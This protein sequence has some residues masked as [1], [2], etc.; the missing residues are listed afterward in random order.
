MIVKMQQND[1]YVNFF[2]SSKFSKYFFN[3]KNKVITKFDIQKT[4]WIW[5]GFF[6]HNQWN[7]FRKIWWNLIRKCFSFALE[8]LPVKAT[9]IV[10]C[11]KFIM[12]QWVASVE[13][14]KELNSFNRPT[15]SG[16]LL[17]MLPF[18]TYLS[19]TWFKAFQGEVWW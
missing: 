13:S 15:W 18:V 11:S 5:N 17:F 19:T 2:Y 14:W 6:F 1:K 8:T 3:T 10:I 9:I 12:F 4:A 7:G 16:L